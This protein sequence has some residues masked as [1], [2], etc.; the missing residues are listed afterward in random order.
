[1]KINSSSLRMRRNCNLELRLSPTSAAAAAVSDHSSA[2]ADGSPQSQQLT[3]FYNGRICVCDVT[4]FQARAILELA[5][6]EMEENAQNETP[7]SILQQSLPPR[8]TTTPGLSMKKSLQRFLQ[9]RK[10]RVQATS[11]YNH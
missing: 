10:H 7:S 5:T 8:P 3:I 1:M 6:R 2:A 9:K 4:E 11:P